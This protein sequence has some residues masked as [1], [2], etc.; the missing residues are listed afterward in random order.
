MRGGRRERIKHCWR[1]DGQ[2][3]LYLYASYGLAPHGFDLDQPHAFA[4]GSSEIA[5]AVQASQTTSKRRLKAN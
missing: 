5:Y 2:V 3:Q 1:C 4:L